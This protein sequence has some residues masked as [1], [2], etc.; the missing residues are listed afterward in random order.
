MFLF[1]LIFSFLL[2]YH[3]RSRFHISPESIH[4]SFFLDRCYSP[5]YSITYHVFRLQYIYICPLSHRDITESCHL[6]DISSRLTSITPAWKISIHTL[7]FS[8]VGDNI[9]CFLSLSYFSPMTPVS[10]KQRNIDNTTR[11]KMQVFMPPPKHNR[12]RNISSRQVRQYQP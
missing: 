4:C 7:S 10:F 12:R 1:A 3:Y 11:H 5:G 2:S 8:S 6:Q 9:T